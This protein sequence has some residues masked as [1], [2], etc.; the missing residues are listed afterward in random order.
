MERHKHQQ[1]VHWLVAVSVAHVT[2]EPL[3]VAPIHRFQ[4]E[5][6]GG[7]VVHLQAIGI[8]MVW[9]CQKYTPHPSGHDF[10]SKVHL[11]FMAGPSSNLK[12][13]HRKC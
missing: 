9:W 10:R 8:S 13:E 7:Q 12:Q 4:L 3:R 2:A 5:A 1:Y 11:G 6:G